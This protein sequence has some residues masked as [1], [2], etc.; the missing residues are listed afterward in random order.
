[1]DIARNSNPYAFDCWQD[2]HGKIVNGA[3]EPD[4]LTGALPVVV[5]V[6]DS[7]AEW[8]DEQVGTESTMAERLAAQEQAQKWTAHSD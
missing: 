8:I 1:M 4:P 2:L 3:T 7:T 5:F 6:I